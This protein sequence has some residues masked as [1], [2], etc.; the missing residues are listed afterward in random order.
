MFYLH[1]F[2]LCFHFAEWVIL[3]EFFHLR[4]FI[5]F[6]I[7]CLSIIIKCDYVAFYI[8]FM[9]KEKCTAIYIHYI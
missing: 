8:P 3:W 2:E 4:I 7:L 6:I 5:T 9:T 1:V